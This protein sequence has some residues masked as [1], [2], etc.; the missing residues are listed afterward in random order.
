MATEVERLLVR[1]EANQRQFEKQ[2]QAASRT[3][4][5][6]A[7]QIESRF[8]KMNAHLGKGFRSLGASI[9]AIGVTGTVIGLRNLASEIATI[10]D[11]AKRAGVGV[12]AFQEWKY[13][14]EQA[15]IPVD[16]LVDGM[17]E[18]NLRADEFVT[19]GKGSAAEAFARLGYGAEELKTKL[20]NPS[21]LMLEIIGRL[22][23]LDKAAQIRIADEIFGGTGGEKFVQLIG[24]G[25]DGI[26]QIIARAHEL[27]A[28]LDKDVIDRAAEVD[29]RFREISTVVGYGLKSAIV[30]AADSLV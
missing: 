4:D 5:S 28:V 19:T 13:V 15:R 9:A 11:E 20:Q 23:Q 25:A 29:K 30:S 6:R 27:G 21:D 12:E 3:A 22:G 8:S 24:M 14:A 2:M 17:K 26:G 7:R 1:L 18:L 10:G 16:A